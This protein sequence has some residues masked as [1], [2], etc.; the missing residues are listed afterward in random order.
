MNISEILKK[1]ISLS[2]K[3]QV[4]FSEIAKS[5]INIKNIKNINIDDFDTESI[6]VGIFIPKSKNKEIAVSVKLV[7]E[8]SGSFAEFLKILQNY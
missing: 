2:P 5:T 4:D 8:T 6:S 7:L 3:K 1:A